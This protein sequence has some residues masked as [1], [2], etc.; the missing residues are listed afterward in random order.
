MIAGGL[1]LRTAIEGVLLG[2]DFSIHIEWQP[3]FNLVK[4]TKKLSAKL[5]EMFKEAGAGLFKAVT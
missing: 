3:H 2:E 5:W 1:P 4:F